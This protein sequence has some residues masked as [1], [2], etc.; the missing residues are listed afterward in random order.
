MVSLSAVRTL[1]NQCNSFAIA[2]DC[3]VFGWTVRT[4]MKKMI[5]VITALMLLVILIAV[6]PRQKKIDS[7]L[8]PVPTE[9][10]Q[11]ERKQMLASASTTEVRTVTFMI[12]PKLGASPSVNFKK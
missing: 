10:A 3:F 9:Q 11:P 4:K 12:Q 1:T 8:A 5:T 6:A 2:E 7:T